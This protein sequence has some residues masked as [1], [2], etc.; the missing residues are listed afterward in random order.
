MDEFSKT[1][2]EDT[3]AIIVSD[4]DKCRHFLKKHFSK[5]SGGI[6]IFH[7]DLFGLWSCKTFDN[8]YLK[9]IEP[10]YDNID[11]FRIVIK[12]EEE[13]TDIKD[14]QRIN[15]HLKMLDNMKKKISFKFYDDLPD[16]DDNILSFLSNESYIFYTRENYDIGENA[17]CV[18]RNFVSN[19]DKEEIVDVK[20]FIIG[21]PKYDKLGRNTLKTPLTDTFITEKHGVKQYFQNIFS[22]ENTEGDKWGENFFEYVKNKVIGKEDDTHTCLIRNRA[23]SDSKEVSNKDHENTTAKNPRESPSVTHYVEN[24]FITEKGDNI[25]MGDKSQINQSN[26]KYTADHGSSAGPGSKTINYQSQWNEVN[27]ND[28]SNL[29]NEL[30]ELFEVLKQRATEGSHYIAI[31]E[32]FKAAEAAKA[33]D[34]S[35]VMECLKSAGKWAWEIANDIGKKVAADALKI[36]LGI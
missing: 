24:L 21:A 10:L 13:Y 3:N 27:N 28:T 20:T 2:W 26:N 25:K 22:P 9:I 29:A 34:G 8:L 19:K 16:T 35:K 30:N 23:S 32:V 4:I 18:Q 15:F 5:G 6:W 12:K 36:A 17:I 11:S 31:G 14:W 1:Y 7:C 33:E